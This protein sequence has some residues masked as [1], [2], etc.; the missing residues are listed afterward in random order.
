[1][2]TG[3]FD[4]LRPHKGRMSMPR[5]GVMSQRQARHRRAHGGGNPRRPVEPLAG[6]TPAPVTTPDRDHTRRDRPH[7]RNL[8][9]GATSRR[10]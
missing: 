8:W 5:R 4:S 7:W 6:R 3:R 9:R 2:I 10:R 1:M